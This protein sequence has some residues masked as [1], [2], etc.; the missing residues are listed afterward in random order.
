ML[1]SFPQ[2]YRHL[3][4]WVGTN[5]PKPARVVNVNSNGDV[6]D[7]LSSPNVLAILSRRRPDGLVETLHGV[8]VAL[9]YER[10]NKPNVGATAYLVDDETVSSSS[11][12]GT[13]PALGTAVGDTPDG[14]VFVY[15]KGLLK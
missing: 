13:R 15:V 5:D 11:S 8:I 7:N 6:T 14:R 1:K 12:S 10:G 9:K 3:G 4:H 2:P